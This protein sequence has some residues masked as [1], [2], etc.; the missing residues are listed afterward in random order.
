MH[1]QYEGKR[2]TRIDYL[3]DGDFEMPVVGLPYHSDGVSGVADALED[4]GPGTHEM[5]AHLVRE[6]RNPHDRNAIRVDVLG[7]TVGY[8]PREYAAMLAPRLDKAG[9]ALEI[10]CPVAVSLD[11]DGAVRYMRLDIVH[12][13]QAVAARDAAAAAAK[14]A[15]LEARAAETEGRC[16]DV[17]S[18][19]AKP[20]GEV[21]GESA[22]VDAITA[23]IGRSA[24]GFS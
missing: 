11:R 17:W 3:G 22:Y 1:L 19:A 21:T 23:I 16:V 24:V 12:D 5:T 15:A 8:M 4:D 9:N 18:I 2:L 20:S 10:T 6:P 14:Q 13:E 7:E